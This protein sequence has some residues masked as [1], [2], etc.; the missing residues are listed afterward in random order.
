MIVT[1]QSRVNTNVRIHQARSHDGSFSFITAPFMMDADHDRWMKMCLDLAERGAG[2]VSPNPMVG[3][4]LVGTDGTMLGQGWHREFGGAHAERH[5]IQDAE[6]RYG[7]D[8][9]KNATLY[10]NLEPCSHHGKTPPCVD[11][12][13]AQG[14]PRVIVGTEDPFPAVSGEGIRRLRDGGVDVT[15]GILEKECRRFNEAFIHHVRTARPLVSLKMAQTL[16]ARIAGAS[17]ASRWISGESSRQRVHHWR[18][19]MDGVMV[20]TATAAQDDPALT[21]RHV[22][23]R[24][25]IRVVL[26]RSGRLDPNLQIFTD[27]HV[28]HT[29][30]FTASNARLAYE[31]AI[32]RL[33]ARVRRVPDTENGLNLRAV[34]KELGR[35]GG[36]DGRPMQSLLVEGGASLAASLLRE[37]LADRLYLFIAPKVLGSGRLSIDDIGIEEMDEALTFAQ[38]EWEMIGDDALFTGYRHEA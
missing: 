28:R 26:D 1:A 32:E 27:D 38:H 23:G 7:D 25:P 9:L 17:G 24:Q 29:V 36:A 8:A 11:E 37:D 33:G 20:G 14:I 34:L 6:R 4:V 19:T 35:D 22:E 16:D 2:K 18:A 3:A 21:V 12:I 10:V 15:V 31:K 30:V 5:A 13:L